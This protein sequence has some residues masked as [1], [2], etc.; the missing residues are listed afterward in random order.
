LT[1]ATG[2]DELATARARKEQR[3]EFVAA[4]GE[5]TAFVLGGEAVSRADGERRSP[6]RRKKP[7]RPRQRRSRERDLPI[8][9]GRLF[10]LYQGRVAGRPNYNVRQYQCRSALVGK[11]VSLGRMHHGGCP[12]RAVFSTAQ[13]RGKRH[14]PPSGIPAGPFDSPE[15]SEGKAPRPQNQGTPFLALSRRQC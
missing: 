14:P 5:I 10:R 15:G 13:W 6:R 8:R 12:P 2:E 7:S 9:R 11:F 3:R 1:G 4:A